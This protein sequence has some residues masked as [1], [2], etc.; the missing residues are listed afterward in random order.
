MATQPLIINNWRDGIGDSPDVGLGYI[1]NASID[2]VPGVIMPNWAPAQVSFAINQVSTGT[3]SGGAFTLNTPSA[4]LITDGIAVTFATTGSLPSGLTAGT[5]YFLYKFSSTQVIVADT[6]AHALAHSPLSITGNGSGTITVTSYDIGTP[7]SIAQGFDAGG[8]AITF[9]ADSNGNVW[10]T[11]SGTLY[12]LSGTT[13]TNATGHGLAL[14]NVS[15]NSATYLF[16]YRNAKVDVCDVTTAAKREDPVGNSCWT[17]AWQS[18]SNGSGFS[19]THQAIVGQDNIIYSCD[20]RYINSIQETP[21]QVFAPGTSAT[22]VWNPKALTL[23]TYDQANCLEQLGLNLLVGGLNSNFIYPWDRSSPSFGL[24]LISPET[25]I[26]GMKNIGNIVWILSGQRGNIYNTMGYFVE[27]AKKIPEYIT[28][29]TSGAINLVTYGGVGAKNG[30]F[31]FGIS[32]LASANAGIYLLFPD[33]RLVQDNTPFA[34]ATLPTILG[35]NSG[36]FYYSGYAGGVDFT[37]ATRYSTLGTTFALSQL[38]LVGTKVGHATF[39]LLE[40]QLD[41]PGTAGGQVRISYRTAITGTFTVLATYT[42]DGTTT[43]F[44]SDIGLTDIEN[45]QLKVEVSSAGTGPNGTHV[46][47][48]RLLQGSQ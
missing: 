38:Y 18:L 31:M 8:T 44:D 27:F 17:V 46:R 12:L 36:E 11:N 33:G 4:A 32:P 22:Y 15:D 24:P 29:S 14:F 20:G 13:L 35:S 48:V 19:G 23:P 9:V 21:G 16:V 2:S 39:S 6:L 37:S 3:F 34:G 41:Q 42:L 45:I 1:A 28:Q 47:E 7:R 26:Y 10:F 43:S 25:S 40:V 30:A 5:V